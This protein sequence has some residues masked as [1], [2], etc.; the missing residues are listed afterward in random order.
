MACK[1]NGATL[2]S[3]YNILIFGKTPKKKKKK[4]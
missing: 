3:I 4:Q 2:L 1:D